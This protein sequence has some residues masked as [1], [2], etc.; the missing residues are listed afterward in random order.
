M[1]FSQLPGFAQIK[2]CELLSSQYHHCTD[3]NERINLASKVQQAFVNLFT[4][5]K[6]D[7]VAASETNTATLSRKA[8]G[9]SGQ[10]LCDVVYANHTGTIPCIDETHQDVTNALRAIPNEHRPPKIKAILILRDETKLIRG[11]LS[12]EQLIDWLQKLISEI[13][14]SRQVPEGIQRTE[15]ALNETRELLTRNKDYLNNAII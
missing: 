5:D 14:L 8:Y 1:N 12:D 11:K 2:A 13:D 3:E 7:A 4:E 9:N 6:P 10:H 15:R